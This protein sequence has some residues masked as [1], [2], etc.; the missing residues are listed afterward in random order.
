MHGLFETH[1]DVTDLNRSL[2]FYTTVLG[3]ELAVRREVDAARVDAHS[4]GARRFALL[5]VGGRGRALLGLWERPRDHIRPQHFAFQV[6]LDELPALV[7]RL[8]EQGI[9]FRDFFQQRTTTPTVFGFIPAASIYFDDPDGH[10]LE[11][12]APLDAP[13][14]PALMAVSWAEWTRAMAGAT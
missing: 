14:R 1:V 10:V 3:L 5:W 8:E 9:A 11:L 6:G 7:A 12:L 13:P 4:R 2:E